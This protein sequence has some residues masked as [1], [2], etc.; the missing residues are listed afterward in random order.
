MNLATGNYSNFFGVG[1]PNN[2]VGSL[3]V[4][5][6]VKA[7]LYIDAGFGGASCDQ[8]DNTSAASAPP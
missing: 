4:G 8:A 6:R 2:W 5:S 7:T 3:K 1:L